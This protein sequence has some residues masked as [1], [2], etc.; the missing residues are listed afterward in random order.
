M[1]K[2]NESKTEDLFGNPLKNPCLGKDGE[3]YDLISMEY[4]F[5]KNS[6]GEYINI[7]YQY[8]EKKERVPNYPRMKNGICLSSYRLQGN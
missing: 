3:I 2:D 5:K 1:E 4:L 6:E 7:P 8:N